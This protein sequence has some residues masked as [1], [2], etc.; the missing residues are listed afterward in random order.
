M[1]PGVHAQRGRPPNLLPTKRKRYLVLFFFGASMFTGRKNDMNFMKIQH[2]PAILLPFHAEQSETGGTLGRFETGNFNDEVFPSNETA[3][4]CGGLVWIIQWDGNDFI[5]LVVPFGSRLG[6]QVPADDSF[7][8]WRIR[9]QQTID[10]RARYPRPHNACLGLFRGC[11]FLFVWCGPNF[12]SKRQRGPTATGSGSEI[13][14]KRRGRDGGGGRG[15]HQ[16]NGSRS[17]DDRIAIRNQIGIISTAR[18]HSKEGRTD[19]DEQRGGGV[20][21]KGNPRPNPSLFRSADDRVK[22]AWSAIEY[23]NKN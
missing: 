9:P 6:S 13:S 5:R 21:G 19:V 4:R 15:V 17:R 11:F 14:W 1:E 10:Y 20:R 2:P 18:T 8:K 3:A 16:P 22:R 7:R 12:R 23:P